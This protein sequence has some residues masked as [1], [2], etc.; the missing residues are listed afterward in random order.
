MKPEG[1]V[2]IEEVLEYLRQDRYISIREAVNYLSLSDRTI[3]GLMKQGLPHFRLR[4]KVL[5]KRSEI[6]EWMEQFRV[7]REDSLNALVRGIFKK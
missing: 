2:A 7:R 4:G 3:R 6:D 1:V 5:F